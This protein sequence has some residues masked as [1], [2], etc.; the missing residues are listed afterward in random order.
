MLIKNANEILFRCSALGHIMVANKQA[1]TEIQ[2]K[3]ITELALKQRTPKQDEEYKLLCAKRDA[4]V[5]LGE[6][7]QT[8]CEDLFLARAWG[9]RTEEES[10]YLKKGHAREEDAI[11]LM[12]RV[13][14]YNRKD[15]IFFQ[16]NTERLQNDW[17]TGECDVFEGDT[18]MTAHTTNDTKCSWSMRTFFASKRKQKPDHNYY[19][20]GQG[21][22]D[23]TGAKLHRIGYCLT[24]GTPEQIARE[25]FLA[26]YNFKEQDPD[27]NPKYVK[28]CQ[29]IEIN[30]IFD[31]RAFRDENPFFTWHNDPDNW[32]WDV[33]L[34]E[35]VHIVE[36]PRNQKDID[37]MHKQVEL[38]REHINV[39]HFKLNKDGTSNER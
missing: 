9:R 19:W 14:N 26:T 33:P 15:K 35:R 32:K 16:K 30:H 21:Y 12:N 3:R 4:P 25:K 23:L 1:L 11:T 37:R 31:V 17:I 2:A 24:N 13:I 39:K 6:S 38:C 10:K 5:E 27:T 7:A 36:V 20:Q 29:Q 28:I 18:I 22:M 8:H 34:L